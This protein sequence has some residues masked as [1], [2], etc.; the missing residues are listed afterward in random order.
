M[1]MGMGVLIGGW[2]QNWRLRVLTGIILLFVFGAGWTWGYYVG[3]GE[4]EAW[5][6]GQEASQTERAKKGEKLLVAYE[7]M[8]VGDQEGGERLLKAVL[9]PE[10]DP[11]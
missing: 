5:N 8:K 2:K 6:R 7:L 1:E 9:V 11:R 3:Q 10:P 4:R